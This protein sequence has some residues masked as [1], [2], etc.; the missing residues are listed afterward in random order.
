MTT[1]HSWS[2]SEKVQVVLEAMAPKANVADI[3]RAHGIHSSQVY[4]WKAAF[5]EGGRHALD[6]AASPDAKLRF[7]NAR[8][9]KLLAEAHLVM[10]G[11][12]ETLEGRPLG[13]AS[14]GG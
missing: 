11:L 8:L 4:K 6:G 9:K 12:R 10:D 5:L 14:G 3:C 1:R 2:T 13:D 7:E